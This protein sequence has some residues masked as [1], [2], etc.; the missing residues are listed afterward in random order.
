VSGQIGSRPTTDPAGDADPPW[1]RQ[2][3][4]AW[5]A[6]SALD[7]HAVVWLLL[8]LG[9]VAALCSAGFLP[10]Y[11]YYQWLFQGHVVSVLLFGTAGS[12]GDTAGSYVL[13]PV[14][15]PNLAA[16]VLIGLYNTFL[17]TETAGLAFVIVTVLGVAIG[18]GHLVR[19]LQRRPTA[20][21]YLGFLWAP[22]FFLYKGYLSYAV[23]P[24][25]MFVL[26][27]ALHRLID[28]PTS[29]TRRYLL[30]VTGLGVLL[31]MSHLLAWVMGGLAVIAHAF[32]LLRRGDRRAAVQ[33]FATMTP[34]VVLAVW[35]VLAEH[36]GSGV[37]LYPSWGE[38][39]IALTETLQLFLRLDP[40]PSPFP[41]FWVNLVLALAFAAL[42][43]SQLDIRSVWSA[44]VARPVLWLSLA[45]AVIA[46]VLPISTVNDLIKPDERFVLPALRL[47]V[48]AL[49]YRA[50]GRRRTTLG[51]V[52]AAVVIALHSIEYTDVGQ[53]IARVDAAIDATV[54]ADTSVL[55]LVVPS[56]YGCDKSA[57]R[58][59]ESRC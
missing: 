22:G 26:L 7:G 58:S 40:F 53:Q 32:V 13:S 41:L 12:A 59:P 6:T 43:L 19:T 38:K 57:G 11:D 10:F 54:P 55:H 9:M 46:L 28:R 15:V 44:V 20:I 30:A 52:L 56:R 21:E 1:R 33:L 5:R 8:S 45:P 25:G 2:R 18:F 34:A 42:V 24:A 3:A 51:P 14:P 49:P 27:A 50:V 47:A 4:Q 17:P 36:G 48:A 35:Y 29:T 23:G 16:P 39:A 31:Y 37:T